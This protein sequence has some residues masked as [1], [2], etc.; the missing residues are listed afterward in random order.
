MAFQL[1][2]DAFILGERLTTNASTPKAHPQPNQQFLEA[3]Q[4]LH[5]HQSRACEGGKEGWY[6]GMEGTDEWT[7]SVLQEYQQI[8]S[9]GRNEKDVSLIVLFY[10]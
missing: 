10:N 5:R 7:N 2:Y 8:L 9:L 3:L 1:T 6:I 4:E